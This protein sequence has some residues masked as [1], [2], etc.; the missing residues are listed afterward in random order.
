MPSS[1][2]RFHTQ[3]LPALSG[4]ASDLL[5]EILNPPAGCTKV[6]QEVVR[7]KQ[8]TVTTS[9]AP[10]DQ[11]EYVTMGTKA[12]ASSASSL[13]CCARPAPTST[14]SRP[15]TTKPCPHASRDDRA[16]HSCA[17]GEAA[18]ARRQQP[19]DKDKM[20]V[21][22]GGALHNA[23]HPSPERAAW[24]QSARAL[25]AYTKGRYVEIDLYVPGVHRRHGEVEEA[26][27][28]SVTTTARGSAQEDDRLPRRQQRR[29]HASPTRRRS[30][31][32]LKA[33]L[34]SWR[35]SSS[36]EP[37]RPSRSR[38]RACPYAPRGDRL[39]LLGRDARE[40]RGGRARARRGGRRV[41]VGRLQRRGQRRACPA[42]VDS[43]RRPRCRGHRARL[44]RR[45]AAQRDEL[46]PRRRGDPDELHERGLLPDP[47]REPLR[48]PASRV[49]R[50]ALVGRRRPRKAA[51]LHVRRGQGG[52][53]AL[54]PGSAVPALRKRRARGHGP[55]WARPHAHDDRS[56]RRTRSSARAPSVARSVVRAAEAGPEDVYVPWYWQPIMATVRSLPERLFQR[57][58]FLAGR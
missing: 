46:R 5:V 16:A 32:S 33:R 2:S 11:S 56:P 7:K 38:W 26:P 1:A 6:T 41:R 55:P 31:E 54:P 39:F 13:T 52:A 34:R 57:F 35:A 4:R 15:P 18:R 23:L 28:L 8:E 22:Y 53:H 25:D 36:S 49:D 30:P 24:S 12:R 37:R 43:P 27:L 47:A 3:L 45:P 40:A 51:Q 14:R 10:T 50:R 29:H 58:A 20:V 48:E 19:A 17:G 21:T 42:R 9:Q 44:A